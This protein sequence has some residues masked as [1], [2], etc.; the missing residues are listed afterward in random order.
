MRIKLYL[1]LVII[2]F[3][4]CTE[5]KDQILEAY[6]PSSNIVVN[7][8]VNTEGKPFYQVQFNNKIVVDTSY[9]GFEFKDSSAFNKNFSIK[10]TTT[11]SVHDTWQMP[12]FLPDKP[13]LSRPYL[14]EDDPALQKMPFQ[15]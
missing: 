10:N 1:F 13:M 4:S 7:F 5:E 6:S 9:L 15:G 3:Y 2:G 14:A 11:T 8:N 12:V